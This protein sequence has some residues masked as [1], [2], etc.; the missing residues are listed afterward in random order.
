MRDMDLVLTTNVAL[1]CE[2]ETF[3]I[4]GVYATYEDFGTKRSFGWA[5]DGSCG[6]SFSAKRPTDEV[7]SK[8][9]ITRDEYYDVCDALTDK[10]FVS[11]CSWCH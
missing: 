6:C 3:E 10:L 2:P 4:N 7:L 1:P 5:G 8:Y 11:G 9:G